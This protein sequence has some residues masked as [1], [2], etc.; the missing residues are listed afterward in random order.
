MY[1]A[2][3]V[4]GG[5]IKNHRLL[6][7]DGTT[8]TLRYANHRRLGADGKPLQQRMPLGVEEFLRRWSEHVPVEHFHMVRTWGVYAA[9]QR[10]ALAQCRRQLLGPPV[11]RPELARSG[12][13]DF[14]AVCPVSGRARVLS[15][16][17]PRA[18]APPRPPPADYRR[19]A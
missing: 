9:T 8:V 11:P 10:V 14:D 16:A 15:A 18:G 4:R 5:P 1:L 12:G 17:I 19:A 7:F 3:Y 13:A 6:A 2:R